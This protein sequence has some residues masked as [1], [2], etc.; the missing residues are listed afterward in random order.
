LLL[1]VLLSLLIRRH[2]RWLLH[3]G[4]EEYNSNSKKIG[5]ERAVQEEP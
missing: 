2:L 5:F 4:D 3:H 1:V